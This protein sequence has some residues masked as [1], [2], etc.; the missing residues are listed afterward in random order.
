MS[1]LRGLIDDARSAEEFTGVLAHEMGH[2]IERHGT[3][4]MLGNLVVQA[5]LTV[6]A[7]DSAR[8]TSIAAEIGLR[9]HSRA[10]E[11]Q[12]DRLGVDMLNK[13]NIRAQP[14]GAWFRRLAAQD[15]GGSANDYVSTHPPSAE[16]AADVERRGT[17]T[18]D[19]MP[20]ED[21]RALKAICARRN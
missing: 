2:G 17:G 1:F 8:W 19:A 4:A 9:A 3:E 20:A 5:L 15:K 16:R 10:A 12:A 13:A 7:G 18:G 6:F 11:R 14:F 21:W